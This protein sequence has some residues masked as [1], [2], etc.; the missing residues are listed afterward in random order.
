[1]LT[2]EGSW[3]LDRRPDEAPGALVLFAVDGLPAKGCADWFGIR[4]SGGSA[5]GGFSSGA[6]A[7]QWGGDA[8]RYSRA[9]T[10]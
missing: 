7:G 3:T 10:G 4:P 9:A 6:F 5:E 2:A 8:E 1:M